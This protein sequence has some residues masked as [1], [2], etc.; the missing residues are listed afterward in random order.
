MVCPERKHTLIAYGGVSLAL[1]ALG[2][3]SALVCAETP[4]PRLIALVVY[5]LIF[6]LLALASKG[7]L[8]MGDAK[9]I[10]VVSVCYGVVDMFMVLFVASLFECVLSLAMLARTKNLRTELPFVPAI[11]LGAIVALLWMI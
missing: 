8:G 9:L 5:G 10:A 2:L 6:I 11:E 1:L 4:L 7:G 3:L